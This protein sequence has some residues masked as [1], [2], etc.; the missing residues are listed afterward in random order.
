MIDALVESVSWQTAVGLALQ[1]RTTDLEAA[2]AAG[3]VG[4]ML[5]VGEERR[6]ILA[7]SD[8]AVVNGNLRARLRVQTDNTAAEPFL[9]ALS[10]QHVT[11]ELPASTPPYVDYRDGA[12]WSHEIGPV[13]VEGTGVYEVLMRE[14]A[15]GDA[16]AHTTVAPRKHRITIDFPLF[17]NVRK[18]Y[19]Q[20][21]VAT[22]LADTVGAVSSPAPFF[23][24]DRFRQ[25][26]PR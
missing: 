8:V 15:E 24:V 5:V 10:N 22:V 26:R 7:V 25:L 14:A 1:I 6:A 23:H 20:A 12:N 19:G 18:A 2:P 17:D 13:P 16:P 4:G 11:I 3:F 21:A 9:F